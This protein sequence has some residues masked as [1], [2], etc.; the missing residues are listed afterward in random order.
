MTESLHDPYGSKV[1]KQNDNKSEMSH[2]AY[3]IFFINFSKQN[4]TECKT[5]LITLSMEMSNVKKNHAYY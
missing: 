2:A 5:V 4:S 3:H 1:G